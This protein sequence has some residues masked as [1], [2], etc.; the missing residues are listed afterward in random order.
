MKYI[1]PLS[2][3]DDD[4]LDRLC[5]NNLLSS[6]P[7][8]AQHQAAIVK[9]YSDYKAAAGAAP[10]SHPLLPTSL[11]TAMR[12]H[13]SSPPERSV[14]GYIYFV[15]NLL[16][17]GVCPTCGAESSATVDHVYPKGLWPVYSFFSLNLV[18]ACDQCNR[19]KDDN[20]F[21]ANPGERPV[22][23]YFDA[24]L[25]D[26]VAM[27]QFNGRYATPALEIVPT[28]TVPPDKLPIV[29][30]HLKNVVRKTQVRAML[31]DRWLSAC[32]DPATYY[33]GL[34]F[35]ASITEAVRAKLD[36]FDRSR[37]TPN[38]WDSMLHSGIL[39]DEGAQQYLA[40]RFLEPPTENPR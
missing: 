20:F 27:V 32:R 8:L 3:V 26:R 15:R 5:A 6:F 40:Q 37:G 11:N 7:E 31:T 14:G 36:S 30:W 33:E 12:L 35:G 19:K 17:P 4:I 9:A 22:H 29:N 16:S 25:K 10:P 24:F 28:P 34:K 38:N 1:E 13:Y 21:G 2:V 39:H 18:P 23:P